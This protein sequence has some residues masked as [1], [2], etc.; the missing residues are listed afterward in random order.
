MTCNSYNYTFSSIHQF[1]KLYTK[2][3]L[4]EIIILTNFDESSFKKNNCDITWKFSCYLE[5]SKWSCY[6]MDKMEI[7]HNH[8]SPRLNSYE[9]NKQSSIHNSAFWKK[10]KSLLGSSETLCSIIDKHYSQSSGLLVFAKVLL[11]RAMI[12]ILIQND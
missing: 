6:F 4:R 10:N 1:L 2:F 12:I 8:S 7:I 3:S 11:Y 5:W 9:E